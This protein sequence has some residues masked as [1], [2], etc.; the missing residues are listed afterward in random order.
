MN[1]FEYWQDAVKQGDVDSVRRLLDERGATIDIWSAVSL[2]RLH[3]ARRLLDEDPTRINAPGGDGKHPLHY[4]KS[5][6]MVDLLVERGADVNARDVDHTS[7]PLQYLIENEPVA[8]RL[9]LQ[10]AEVDIFAA[11]ALGD[12]ELV[13]ACIAADPSA[14]DARLGCSPWTND[15]GG[16]I[17]N[18]T[19]GHD[20]A[21]HDVARK[22]RHEPVLQRLIQASS[23]QRQLTDAIWNGDEVRVRQVIEQH[24]NVQQQLNDDDRQMLARAAWSYRPA[25]VRLMLQLGFDPHVRGVHDSTPLDRASFHGY[26]D[27][28][29]MLLQHDPNPPLEQKNEFGG[30]P[31]GA[32]L[33]GLCHGWKTG[34]P[35]DHHRTVLLLLNASAMIAKNTTPTG[36]PEIDR[37]LGISS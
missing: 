3:D 29:E 35:Q 13:N 14:T 31:L 34:H 36:N 6:A 11:A 9:I 33:H 32:C 37:V 16:L 17:Y 21:P 27:I 12:M 28:V 23:P 24:R 22:R 4:A 19:L 30:T 20:L 25:A 8:R 2:D 1:S 5:V 26:A 15:A 7:T 18:W 10:G